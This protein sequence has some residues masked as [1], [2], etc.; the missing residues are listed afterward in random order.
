MD[1]VE[2]EN[3]FAGVGAGSWLVGRGQPA[4]FSGTLRRRPR[5]GWFLRDRAALDLVEAAGGKVKCAD[6]RRP[7]LTHVPCAAEVFAVS[8]KVLLAPSAARADA[9]LLKPVPM[10]ARGAI[11][12]TRFSSGWVV[13]ATASRTARAALAEGETLSV[14]P[15]ALVAWT[16]K[17]PTGFCRKLSVWDVL[18][19]RLPRD[20]MLTFYGPGVVWIEG[21]GGRN[22]AD[23]CSASGNRRRA[24]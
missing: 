10:G 15:E 20:L 7:F 19:P 14:R 21:A 12:V 23:G 5:K 24:V 1:S 6:A 2:I 13:F 18:L 9:F 8:A 11:G 4:A 22:A 3:G 16:G 17:R